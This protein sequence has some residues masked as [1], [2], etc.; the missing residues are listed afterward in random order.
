MSDKV[1]IQDIA[2][3]LGLSRN[4]V[5]KAINN[6]GVLA[7]STRE[8]VLKKAVEMGYKQFS[9][10]AS[11]PNSALMGQYSSKKAGEIAVMLGGV[12]DGSHFAT[13]MLDKFQM[14]ISSLGYTMTIHRISDENRS[15][16]ELPVTFIPDNTKGIL[17]VELFDYEY[18]KMLTA[19]GIPMLMA[20]GPIESFAKGLDVDMLLMNNTNC[21]F[22]II[23]KLKLQ[24]I[25]KI[26]FVGEMNHCRS[27]FERYAA[28]RDAMY[29]C[30]LSINEDYNL[31]QVHAHGPE[32]PE[33]LFKA[34]S[35]MKELPELFIC[36]NDFV[37]IDLLQGLK[38]MNK[39]C[40]DDVLICGFDDSPESRFITPALTTCHIHSQILGFSAAQLLISRI[41]QP[42]LNYRTLYA[43]TDLIIR[44]STAIK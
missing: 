44:E 25:T 17:C 7:D 41:N 35:K 14:E 20:D 1:T 6:T 43:E 40:P 32:Y 34:L 33:H 37:A 22:E 15:K 23:A 36:A 30:G 4:T 28:F 42:D 8:K 13:T 38:K 29:L 27:F 5:S 12:V 21:I 2:D 9:Y 3:A 24:G 19:L 10:I 39:S 16:K 11:M 26:G 31:T 18:C